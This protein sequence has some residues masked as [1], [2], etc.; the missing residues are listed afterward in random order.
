MSIMGKIVDG[1]RIIHG[2]VFGLLVL[3]IPVLLF[4]AMFQMHRYMDLD[5]QVSELNGAQY[6]LIDSNRRLVSDISQLT[7]SERI[8]ELATEVYG[9]HPAKSEE[10]MRVEVQAE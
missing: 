3:S 1:K 7:S 2:T 6:E 10:I 9:M 4:L 5:N 8:E